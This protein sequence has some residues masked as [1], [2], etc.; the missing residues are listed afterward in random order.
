MNPSCYFQ[1]SFKPTWATIILIFF[2]LALYRS[3]FQFNTKNIFSRDKSFFQGQLNWI[4]IVLRDISKTTNDEILKISF[5]NSIR[6]TKK[7]AGPFYFE[8]QSNLC[9]RHCTT[10]YADIVIVITKDGSTVRY[11]GIVRYASIFAKK[12]C[13][14][15]WYGTLFL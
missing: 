4:F 3:I 13:M 15:R 9:W 5:Q 1:E 11:V 6:L 12:Y 8:N 2:Y 14:V 7:S 10:S